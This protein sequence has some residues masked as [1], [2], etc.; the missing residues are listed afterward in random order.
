MA[1]GRLACL[2]VFCSASLLHAQTF[3]GG[4]DNDYPGT[5][6]NTGM[7]EIGGSFYIDADLRL[8]T[9]L[10]ADSL[11][12]TNDLTVGNIHQA[13]P[14]DGNQTDF[15]MDGGLALW[16]NASRWLPVSRGAAVSWLHA[17]ID[18]GDLTYTSTDT[19]A[20]NISE[21]SDG[22]FFY[23]A[24]N[25]TGYDANTTWVWQQNGLAAMSNASLLVPQMELS[26]HG[27]LTLSSASGSGTLQIDPDAGSINVST[28]TANIAVTAGSSSNL[29]FATGNDT[30]VFNDAASN[31]TQSISPASISGAYASGIQSLGFGANVQVPGWGSFAFGNNLNAQYYGSVVL[32]DANAFQGNLTTGNLTGW[33][34]ADPL[35]LV[36]NGGEADPLTVLKNG[37][38]VLTGQT[39]INGNATL[40]GVLSTFHGSVSLGAAGNVT[41]KMST[42]QGDIPQLGD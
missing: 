3:L 33:Q 6:Y 15:T 7:V 39:T 27:N 18:L 20:F 26:V 42:A 31:T 36:G 23:P 25:F 21:N 13:V 4:V 17:G 37:D 28:P 2:V 24:I 22:T 41:V 32:G 10:S 14:M 12:I 40:N 34:A 1:I 11:V 29:T 35:F 16:S 8:H 19:P 9:S 5:S 38:A 30:I